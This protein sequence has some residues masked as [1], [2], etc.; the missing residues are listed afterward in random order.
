MYLTYLYEI[1]I[2]YSFYG[3]ALA[4]GI[5]FITILL[6]SFFTDIIQKGQPPAPANTDN[7]NNKKKMKTQ[8]LNNVPSVIGMGPQDSDLRF[9]M[10]KTQ[11]NNIIQNEK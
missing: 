1:N 4:T 7:E 3:M 8:D 10:Q 2:F 9:M 6:L 11:F 5:G